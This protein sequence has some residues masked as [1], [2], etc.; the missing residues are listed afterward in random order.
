MVTKQIDDLRKVF[1]LDVNLIPISIE[2]RV[3]SENELVISYFEH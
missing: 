3:K 1:M 2:I